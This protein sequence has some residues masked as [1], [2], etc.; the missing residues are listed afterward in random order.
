MS[1]ERVPHRPD[2]APLDDRQLRV[3]AFEARAW[4]Q[5]ARKAEAIRDE[6]GISAA[7]YYRILGELIDSPAAL[8]HDPMLVKRLQRLRS[9]RRAA[10][11]QRSLSLGRPLD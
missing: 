4:Q 10:R 7:R 5:P 9:A 2:D 3:L 6:F 1:A 11:S 8:R